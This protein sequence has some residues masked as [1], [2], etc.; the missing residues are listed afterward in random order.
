[1]PT[2]YHTPR[3]ETIRLG[4]KVGAGGEGAV[5]EV[6]GRGEVVAKIYHETPPRERAEKLLAL[7]RLGN[8]RLLKLAAWPVD[9]LRVEA[10]GQTAGFLMPR[11]GQAEEVHALH[12]PKSRLQKFPDASWAFLIHAAANIARAVA[13]IHEHGFVIGDVNPKNIFVTRQATVCLL[14]CDSFQ[15]TSEGKTYRSEGGFPEYTPPELQG[16]PLRDVDRTLAHDCFGLAVVIFQLLFLGRHP[17]SGRFAGA[18]EMPLEQAVKESRF[19]YGAGAAARQM[20]PPPG[21]L[22]FDA[23]PPPIADLFTRAF[24]SAHQPANRPAPR[25]WIEA[26]EAMAKSLTR[27]ALHS[28]HH[29][30]QSLAACPWCEIESRA[31]V[32]LFNFLMPGGGHQR[33]GFRLADIWREIEA[34]PEPMALALTPYSDVVAAVTPSKEAAARAREREINFIGSLVF[35]GLAGFL[36][37]LL[38]DHPLAQ[39]LAV[40]VGIVAA[41]ATQSGV[42]DFRKVTRRISQRPDTSHDALPEKLRRTEQDARAAAQLL[43]LRWEKEASDGR[44]RSKL[45]ALRAQKE[46]YE[47]LSALRTCKLKELES[48]AR[49]SQLRDFLDGF[50]LDDAE[51]RGVGPTTKATLRTYGIKTAANVTAQKLEPVYRVGESRA[52]A[53]ME[54][55]RELEQRFVFD[56]SNAVTTQARLAVEKEIDETRAALEREL[57]SGAFYLRRVKQEIEDARPKLEPA[58]TEARRTLAQAEKDL[59]AVGKQNSRKPVVILLIAA[60]CFGGLTDVLISLL[61]RPIADPPYFGVLNPAPSH[62][63]AHTLYKQGIALTNEGKFAEAVGKLRH[64]IT[65]DSQMVG[66]YHEL[67]YALYRLGDYEESIR[68]STQALTFFPAFDPYY[69]LGLAYTAQENWAQAEEAF[70]QAIDVRQKLSWTSWHTKFTEACYGHS[71]ALV[72]LGAAEKV[73]PSLEQQLTPGKSSP[74]VRF[75][76][77]TLYLLTGRTDAAKAQARLLKAENPLAATDLLEL[78]NQQ[79]G[80]TSLPRSTQPLNKE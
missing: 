28:G 50:S 57:S 22:A 26:L 21:T 71:F 63:S 64:A 68:V 11:V 16:V 35:A 34:V 43:L 51:I 17:F 23:L 75:E 5:Y 15:V 60:F 69:N 8:A 9:V 29:Y 41:R 80:G 72:Q 67:G 12:S 38:T 78:I 32:R 20:Q 42:A 10:S 6:E 49:E 66:A 14:D 36:I 53:L 19:A 30:L 77:G 45:A 55:R 70:R 27:C 56:R 44:F 52:A 58:V 25:E 48:A 2:T 40:T 54:W 46:A 7:A 59:D 61:S 73:M 65:R 31:G 47:E 62:E 3:G 24:L 18:G 79:H 37:P 39:W 74:W 1:M 4:P 13:A 33:G 76:L